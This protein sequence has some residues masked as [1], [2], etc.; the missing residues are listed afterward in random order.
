MNFALNVSNEVEGKM[1][2]MLA[3]TLESTDMIDAG[4][5]EHFYRLALEGVLDADPRIRA[6]GDIRIGES[7]LLV[8]SDT[9]VV[10]LSF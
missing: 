10:C 6:S 3:D 1:L 8:D 7:I 9:K 4:L 5:E 2:E